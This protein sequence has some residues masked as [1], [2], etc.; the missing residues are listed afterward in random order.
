MTIRHKLLASFITLL[1]VFSALCLYL[2]YA[3]HKQGEQTIF[4]FNQPLNAVN[5][6]SAAANIFRQASNFS[7]DVLAFKTPRNSEQVAAEFAHFQSEF[8]SHLSQA[9]ASSLTESAMELSSEILTLSEQ[10]FAQTKHHL[11]GGAQ[12]ALL[13]LRVLNSLET[14][15]QT[16]LTKLANETQASAQQLA[17]Q[18]TS[19][20]D[21]Q[22]L[23][24]FILLSVI[25]LV[26]I[27]SVFFLTSGLLKPLLNLKD[28]VVELARGDGDLTRRLTIQ[29]QDEV[30]QLSSEF[31]LF[32]EK[33]HQS[34][35]AISES[36][37]QTQ[38]KVHE[39][40]AISQ[41]T[42]EGTSEQK[43]KIES[44]STA[45]EQVI[46]S[47]SSVS[48][49]S[50][51]AQQQAGNIYQDTEQGVC[52]INQTHQD[53]LGLANK[54]EQASD[55][56]FELSHS[57]SEI[58][59]VLEVIETIAEQT[60][61]LALNAAIEAARAGEAGRGFSVVADEVRNLAMKTQ[62]STLNIQKT[63]SKIQQQAAM[64]KDMMEQGREEARV[65]AD[66]NQQLAVALEQILN[67]AGDI[68]STSDVV[69]E[70]TKQ[71][72]KAINHVNQFLSSIV[73]IADDTAQGSLHLQNNS[74]E[75][76]ASM[77]RVE[78]KVGEFKLC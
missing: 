23:S 35:L 65:C 39:F 26:A 30:G 22:M 12:S 7:A 25:A 58:G 67:R 68:K 74:S 16:R 63:V 1:V 61:L 31:N 66:K 33:V 69:S 37:S 42:Q 64:A 41:Q 38:Q 71:Q 17:E 3:L 51:Q 70:H 6:S 62:E 75:V 49:S 27:V 54:V 18:V 40:S 20:I 57:S 13:D 4:A 10:W 53:M 78:A 5:S 44:I 59:S 76:I 55:V 32:I 28:A 36:V 19:D 50:Q 72:D 52:L 21:A 15:I 47:V 73:N 48:D 45:M 60:N 9:K 56:I 11:S 14:D 2:T 24:V 43:N 34:V 77:L 8:E 29:R 46:L